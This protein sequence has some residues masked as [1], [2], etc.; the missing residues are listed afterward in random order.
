MKI[1]IKTLL[2]LCFVTLK[3]CQDDLKI[4]FL[5]SNKYKLNKKD[6]TILKEDLERQ[7]SQRVFEI[8]AGWDEREKLRQSA[9]YRPPVI[10]PYPIPSPPVNIPLNRN[11]F[12]A[13]LNFDNPSYDAHLFDEKRVVDKD[14][15]EKLNN[16]IEAK[17]QKDLTT[18]IALTRQTIKKL[19]DEIEESKQAKQLN[20]SS[21]DIV[22][23]KNDKTPL[24]Y[25]LQKNEKDKSNN[26]S[27]NKIK[28]SFTNS[29][30][31][32]Y[33]DKSK[34]KISNINTENEY[35]HD[36]LDKADEILFQVENG[37]FKS[38]SR[39]KQ[40]NNISNINNIS[41]QNLNLNNKVE[42]IHK[43]DLDVSF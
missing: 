37:E 18:Q 30:K 39:F 2:L 3:F 26:K 17:I 38:H 40:V 19:Q 41:S 12:A 36:N 25:F 10:P 4:N 22:D 28:K 34:E 35:I 31:N 33:I 6:L 23:E 20:L 24:I 5:P 14:L 11:N 32:E 29:F 1:Y 27:N 7:I 16:M 21:T 9:I 15:D 43:K 8:Q 42:N 13:N